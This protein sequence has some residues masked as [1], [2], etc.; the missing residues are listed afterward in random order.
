MVVKNVK[1]FNKTFTG[2]NIFRKYIVMDYMINDLLVQYCKRF[3][4]YSCSQFFSYNSFLSYIQVWNN[5][6]FNG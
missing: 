4:I 3:T 6:H 1:Y 5:L 2:Q